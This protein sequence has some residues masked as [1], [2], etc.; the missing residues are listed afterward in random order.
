MKESNNF[1][2]R[3]IRQ[4]KKPDPALQINNTGYCWVDHDKLQLILV[5]T[6]LPIEYQNFVN[7]MERLI[8]HPYS[9]RYKEFIDKYRRPLAN[10]KAVDD[11]P[12]PD[13]DDKGRSF[14]TVYGELR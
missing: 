6:I 2:D 10:Q 1:E 4:Q 3:M 9:Y 13:V 7:T 12:T 11:I 8:S 5:E 14:V